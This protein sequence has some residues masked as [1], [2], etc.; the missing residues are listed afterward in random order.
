MAGFGLV[1]KASQESHLSIKGR[2]NKGPIKMS[3]PFL[4]PFFYLDGSQG[5]KLIPGFPK[6]L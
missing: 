4:K 1:F 6:Y 3:N 5:M 2:K